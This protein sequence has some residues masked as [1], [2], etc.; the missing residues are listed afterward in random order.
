NNPPTSS[1]TFSTSALTANFTDTSTDTDGSVVSWSWDFGGDGTSNSQNPS[2]TFSADGTFNV[3]LTVTDDL[4]DTG[5]TS[6]N[7]TVS[8]GGGGGSTMHIEAITTS[9]V[10]GAGGVGFAEA[11]FLIHDDS[12]NPVSGA[13]VD[14]TFG[15][16]LTGTDTGVT[17]T[18]GEV[19]LAS[20]EFT[21]RPSDL[22]ICASNVTSGSLT[23]DPGQN[24]DSSFDCS[25]AAP[26]ARPTNVNETPERFTLHP[27]FPN[28]FNPTTEIRFSL[29]DSGPVRISIF[30]A[31]GQEVRVLT[32]GNYNMG[33]HS[34]TWDGKDNSGANMATGSYLYQLRFNNRVY[35]RTMT[36]IK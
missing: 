16:D 32:D 19:V 28:P 22:G 25:T 20:E 33:E 11:T 35:T 10:R 31:L 27:N 26:G 14:G 5:T 29:E 36:M 7:V 23:Y 17:D 8:S 34:V 6:Q 9:I 4:G 21:S 3:S 24:S 2:H 18:N 13:T 15:G 1:F 12:G 30:N